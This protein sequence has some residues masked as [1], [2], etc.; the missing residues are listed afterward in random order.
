MNELA[1]IFAAEPSEMRVVREI[2]LPTSNG[3]TKASV[4]MVEIEAIIKAIEPDVIQLLD[5]S[6]FNTICKM[7]NKS[8]EVAAEP[9]KESS[10][11]DTSAL[12]AT[13]MKP[14]EWQGQV[15]NMFSLVA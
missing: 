5:S 3:T 4:R 13:E 10:E 15:G 1:S 11:S 12:V 6:A 7:Q 2:E 9:Q 8:V 14:S